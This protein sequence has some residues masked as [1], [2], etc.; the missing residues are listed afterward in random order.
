MGAQPRVTTTAEET[1]R[2]QE[3]S[4]YGANLVSETAESRTGHYLP[5][6]FQPRKES[7]ARL[8][9]TVCSS[10]STQGQSQGS[11]PQTT[12]KLSRLSLQAASGQTTGDIRPDSSREDPALRKLSHLTWSRG[13][14]PEKG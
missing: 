13:G 1:V 3:P 7:N 9:P 6:S 8:R 4:P 2:S 14:A 10:A 11:G 5:K 12:S